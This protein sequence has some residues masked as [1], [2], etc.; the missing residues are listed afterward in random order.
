MS[1]TD[2]KL[3]LLAF[4]IFCALLIRYLYIIIWRL[5]FS[6]VAKF[7]GPKLAA[8]TS[9]YEFY[10]DFVKKGRYCYEIERMHKVYGPIVRIN[11]RELSIC[12]SDYYDKLYVGGYVRP[13]EIDAQFVSGIG[14]ERTF[15]LTVPHALHRKLRKP[16]EP[17]FSCVGVMRIEG[18]INDCARKLMKRFEDLK[19][20]ERVVRLDHAMLAYTGDVVGHICVDNPKEL[21]ADENFA[22]EWYNLHHSMVRCIP[23]LQQIPWAINILKKIPR[24]LVQ[25]IDPKFDAFSAWAEAANKH[26]EEVVMEK[27]T[28]T[29]KRPADLGGKMTVFRQLV[30]DDTLD[31]SEWSS[32]RLSMEAQILMGA[33][34]VSPARTLHFITFFL[35][36]NEP[37][38]KRLELELT[39]IMVDWPASPPKWAQLEKLPYLQAVIKEGLRHSYGTMH[40]LPRISACNLQYKE[41]TIPSG[42]PVG[43]TAYLQHT[44]LGV[45]PNPFEFKP[46]RW[47]GPD[48]N[49]SRQ[50]HR[51]L[52]PFSRGSRNCIGMHLAYA[53]VTLL[54]AALF[55]P[56]APRME[57]FE[58]D[59]TDVIAAHDYIVPLPRLDSKGVRVVIRSKAS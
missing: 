33:G 18:L 43:M 7:P 16:F 15:F 30:N 41:W 52:V 23:L 59:E 39:D 32:K 3:C 2:G 1:R 36:S 56:G 55:R 28:M 42:V 46:D 37:M 5:Y 25:W 10:Y 31:D 17:Y 14:F 6:P 51:N 58:T 40:R 53:E 47:L 44:D 48:T 19:D 13:T 21:I 8:I 54:L 27:R 50:M 29:A 49:A 38:R 26:I 22:P 11:P 4:A 57:L 20:S 12:D 9:L 35:L 24:G 45:F 34:S